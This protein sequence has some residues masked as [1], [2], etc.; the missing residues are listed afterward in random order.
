MK[1]FLTMSLAVFVLLS[2]PATST[3]AQTTQNPVFTVSSFKFKPTPSNSTST[4]TNAG[5][6]TVSLYLPGY[7]NLLG[8]QPVLTKAS[9][10]A[11][12]TVIGYGS[13]DGI[14]FKALGDTVTVTNQTT[15]SGIFFH[16]TPGWV[17]YRFISTGATTFSGTMQVYYTARHQ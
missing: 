4:Q 2:V 3:K 6:D 10:T 1:K 5:S 14:N 12:G 7:Y 9:G 8:L 16:T 13:I 17:Y 15:N 11:A